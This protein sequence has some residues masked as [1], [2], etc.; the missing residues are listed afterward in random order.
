MNRNPW[1]TITLTFTPMDEYQIPAV[2]D[3]P[4]L[5]L[6]DAYHD[7]RGNK[8]CSKYTLETMW[9]RKVGDEYRW[10][11]DSCSDSDSWGFGA[12]KYYVYAPKHLNY[13]N[14]NTCKDMEIVYD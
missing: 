1:L 5:V 12:V 8:R 13:Q 7:I 9:L 2:L 11:E 3:K 4:V 6:F 14:G 10:Y